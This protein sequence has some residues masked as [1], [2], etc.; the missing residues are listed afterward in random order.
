MCENRKIGDIV[1]IQQ[2]GTVQAQGQFKGMDDAGRA[3]VLVEGVI[4]TGVLI[5][6]QPG[7]DVS[8]D[9]PEMSI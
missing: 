9:T 1:T 5:S 6:S 3:K 4:H 8:A 2:A 7:N